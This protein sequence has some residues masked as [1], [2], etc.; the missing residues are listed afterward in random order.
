[1]DASEVVTLGGF[2]EESYDGCGVGVDFDVVRMFVAVLLC[3]IEKKCCDICV[4]LRLV[5]EFT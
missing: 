1:V 2:V 5:L 3:S 4:A